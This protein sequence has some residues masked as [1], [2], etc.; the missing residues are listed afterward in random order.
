[1]KIEDRVIVVVDKPTRI[2]RP[3][4]TDPNKKDKTKAK[5]SDPSPYPKKKN[6]AVRIGK[7]YTGKT[8]TERDRIRDDKPSEVTE[9][10]DQVDDDGHGPSVQVPGP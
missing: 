1:M 10:V 6:E 2:P 5:I 3:N 8:R 9:L 7:A 4:H